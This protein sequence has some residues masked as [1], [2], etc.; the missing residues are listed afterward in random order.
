MAME[1]RIGSNSSSDDVLQVAE[2]S[3]SGAH[4]IGAIQKVLDPS[5]QFG[6][7]TS[8]PFALLQRPC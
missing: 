4:M 2:S 1:S 6:W 7:L 5:G 3:L 8:L